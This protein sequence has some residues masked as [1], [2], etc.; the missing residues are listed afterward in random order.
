MFVAKSVIAKFDL[1]CRKTIC[2]TYLSYILWT[3]MFDLELLTVIKYTQCT[4]FLKFEIVLHAKHNWPKEFQRIDCDPE[5]VNCLSKTE[6]DFNKLRHWYKYHYL[7]LQ[8]SV[9]TYYSVL[10]DF[11]CCFWSRKSCNDVYLQ[12][13]GRSI[14]IPQNDKIAKSK[15]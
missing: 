15:N 5:Y 10:P 9:H 13:R 7:T 3:F 2:S 14:S 8:L 6:W 12:E 1:T 4:G 11:T